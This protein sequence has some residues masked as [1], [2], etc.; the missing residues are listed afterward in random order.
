MN[1]TEYFV[2]LSFILCCLIQASEFNKSQ[3]VIRQLVAA[4]EILPPSK[5]EET[6][7]ATVSNLFPPIIP[8]GIREPLDPPRVIGQ[9]VLA[10]V[11]SPNLASRST[12][13]F[14]E[15]RAL[16]EHHQAVP[17]PVTELGLN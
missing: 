14:I 7:S 9:T 15:R 6:L 12:R 17:D 13:C 11:G 10:K 4:L 2:F 5:K 3:Y 1:L 16:R 8:D